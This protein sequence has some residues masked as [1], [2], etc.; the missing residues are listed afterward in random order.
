M[1]LDSQNENEGPEDEKVD[2]I[3]YMY[4]RYKLCADDKPRDILYLNP[5]E[6][7]G[8]AASV[9]EKFLSQR[10]NKGI[11]SWAYSPPTTR[12]GRVTKRDQ[13]PAT[14]AEPKSNSTHGGSIGARRYS[15]QPHPRGLVRLDGNRGRLPDKAKSLSK[16]SSADN[17]S[18]LHKSSSTGSPRPLGKSTSTGTLSTHKRSIGV[19]KDAKAERK[20]NPEG[21]RRYSTQPKGTGTRL[22]STGRRDG[23]RGRLPDRAKSLQE[24]ERHSGISPSPGSHSTRS[25]E[26]KVR[27]A[28]SLSPEKLAA[29]RLPKGSSSAGR[30]ES[31]I[32]FSS[33]H[34]PISQSKLITTNHA[35]A[36][37]A[38]TE[39]E[40]RVA[41]SLSPEKVAARSRRR[42]GRSPKGP[43]AATRLSSSRDTNSSKPSRENARVSKDKLKT[44]NHAVDKTAATE[45]GRRGARSLSPEKLAAARS[46][47]SSSHGR[48]CI[49]KPS[50]EHARASKGTHTTR[51]HAMDKTVAIVEEGRAGGSLSP[52]KLV[53]A[54]SRRSRSH[55]RSPKGPSSAA[56]TSSKRDAS[57]TK[58]SSEHLEVGNDSSKH[59]EAEKDSSEHLVDSKDKHTTESPTT[60]KTAAT[61]GKIPMRR[62]RRQTCSHRRTGSALQRY[63]LQ[64]NFSRVIARKE[65]EEEDE[66]LEV[67][68]DLPEEKVQEFQPSNT[69]EDQGAKN[70]TLRGAATSAANAAKAT[71]AFVTRN[72]QVGAKSKTVLT[73][74]DAVSEDWDFLA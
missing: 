71:V 51:N 58:P 4:G 39:E 35:T 38:A 46:R 67:L 70:R 57:S 3:D 28:R 10:L 40:G 41:R 66:N 69:Q 25:K 30:S 32:K 15:T 7:L 14:E 54:R 53:A 60:I 74:F 21:L 20:S 19:R 31:S 65:G 36:K 27:V 68:E 64:R 61:C 72:I 55:V 42:Q 33:E 6:E 47:S 5:V 73:N 16:S 22:T 44:A 59:L 45:E 17:L 43:S 63:Q 29:A 11:A 62:G 18:T 13:P 34:A 48:S 9:N 49:L 8:T 37:T 23:D 50:R 12:D 26:E 52:E 56:R 2:D 24:D 1:Q